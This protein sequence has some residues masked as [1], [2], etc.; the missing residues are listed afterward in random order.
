[1]KAAVS[2]WMCCAGGRPG[3]PPPPYPTGWYHSHTFALHLSVFSFHWR[4]FV[5]VFRYAVCS[6]RDLPVKY[7]K[8]LCRVCSPLDSYK[9][10]AGRLGLWLS[11]TGACKP[12]ISSISTWCVLIFIMLLW[13]LYMYGGLV[14]VTWRSVDQVLYRGE[15]GKAVVLDGY[16]PH[17]GAHLGIGGVVRNNGIV[18]PFHG[19]VFAFARPLPLAH[20]WFAV[21]VVALVRCVCR[22]RNAQVD[23]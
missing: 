10:C 12:F 15:D 1:M 4:F 5:S 13:V 19:S 3:V 20:M 16:C 7:S 8:L 21:C 6:S 23:V 22:S 9:L 11:L 17:L 14:V 2:H 18:C